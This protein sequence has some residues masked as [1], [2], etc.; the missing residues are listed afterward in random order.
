MTELMR[1]NSES[2][3]RVALVS[4][5]RPDRPVC[6]FNINIYSYP[7]ETR[8]KST[9]TGSTRCVTLYGAHLFCVMELWYEY[10]TAHYSVIWR[11]RLRAGLPY[12][13]YS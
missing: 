7:S 12:Y 10:G 4:K 6:R 1:N 11:V 2:R 8:S 5:C 9:H 3:Y 13:S